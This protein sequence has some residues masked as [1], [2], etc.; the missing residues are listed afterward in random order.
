M[1][2]KLEPCPF[3]GGNPEVDTF[4]ITQGYKIYVYNI[5]CP[6]CNSSSDSYS[7]YDKA[8]RAWNNRATQYNKGFWLQYDD[9]DAN[10]WECSICHNVWQLNEGNPEDNHMNFCPKCGACLSMKLGDTE[11][12]A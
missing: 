7:S 11:A 1:S 2:K 3:C 9:E 6:K 8:V 12:T 5:Q 10:A 4:D